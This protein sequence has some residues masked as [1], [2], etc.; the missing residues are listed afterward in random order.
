MVGKLC[1]QPLVCY[2]VLRYDQQS[3]S[4]LIQSM[5]DS[6]PCHTTDPRQAPAAMMEKR[7]DQSVIPM[8]SG[9]MHHHAGWFVDDY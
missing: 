8:P 2:V 7:V 4:V 9:R 3:A 1:R 6:R 5:H